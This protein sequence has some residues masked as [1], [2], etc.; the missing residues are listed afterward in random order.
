MYP[1][2]LLL[3]L[4]A[5][6]VSCST[7]STVNDNQSELMIPN[8]RLDQN[9]KIIPKT[10]VLASD[11][12]GN[13]A[14]DD[15]INMMVAKHQFNRNELLELFGQVKKLDYV[16]RLMDR[17]NIA[18]SVIPGPH[19]AWLR[20]R[21]AFITPANIDRGVVFWNQYHEELAKAERQY[22]VPPE[23]I[24]GILGVETHWGRNT[25]KTR[26]IDSLATLAFNYPRRADYFR[27]ELETYLVYAREEQLDPLQLL[28]SYAGAMG[29]GQF[30]PS[31][32]RDFAVNFKGTGHIDLWDPVDAIGSVAHY[33]QKHGWQPNQPVAIVANGRPSTLKDGYQTRYTVA[34]LRKHGLKPLGKLLNSQ[35]V[36]LL[37]LD[38]GRHYQY[39]FGL[40]N[41]YAI[42]RYNHSTYYA[43]AVWQLG[44]SVKATR[45]N[46][47]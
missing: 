8:I 34:E 12:I 28:G 25:G 38:M 17:Q 40:N 39:W 4:A 33:F 18:P 1:K 27:N 44:E 45:N 6:L 26:V 14:V 10:T 47:L 15:F 43:M 46:L 7:Y 42:T 24:V 22:G 3:P 41:F 16:L 2:I 23:I 37:K 9:Q 29:Y 32:Y 21:K 36:S 13:S 5:I 11:F 31:A 20:Y 30:M 19:G 35:Q